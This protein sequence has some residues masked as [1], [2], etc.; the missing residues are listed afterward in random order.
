MNF[1]FLKL[2]FSLLVLLVY[3]YSYEFELKGDGIIV[4]LLKKRK[5]DILLSDQFFSQN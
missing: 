5:S 2:S 3:L 1:V 4:N